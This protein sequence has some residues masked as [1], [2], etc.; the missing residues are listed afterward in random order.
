MGTSVVVATRPS[1]RALRTILLSGLIAGFLDGMDA[2]VFIGMI[3]GVPVHRVFQFIA[4]GALG[5]AAF[6]DGWPAVV[7]GVFFHFTIALA[8]AA[9][10]YLLSRKLPMVLKTP[11]LWGPIYGFGVFLFMHYVVVPLSAAPRQPPATAS[12]IAN[13]IFSHVFFVGI[14]IALINSRASARA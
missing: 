12:A 1:R 2:V 4:S 13:L 5:V 11:L 3:G 10:Y 6:H 9:V 14:P 8:A 7:L